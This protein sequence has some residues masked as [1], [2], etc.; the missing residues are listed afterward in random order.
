MQL[1]EEHR[2][3]YS[4]RLRLEQQLL[5]IPVKGVK[6]VK[7][8]SRLRQITSSKSLLKAADEDIPN[9]TLDKKLV[10]LWAIVQNLEQDNQKTR[11]ESEADKSTTKDGASQTASESAQHTTEAVV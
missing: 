5:P 4:I 10:E 11:K 6:G 9:S 3:T 8:F 2:P 7:G 1:L